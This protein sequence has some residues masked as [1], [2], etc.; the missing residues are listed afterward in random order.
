MPETGDRH[1]VIG[2]KQG[3]GTT[4]IGRGASL[5]GD[6]VA[7]GEIVIEGS[8]E[9]SLRADGAR[10]T[11]GQGAQV[12]ADVI[13]Q[14]VIVEGHVYGAIRASER[15]ELRSTAVVDGNVYSK[16]FSMEEE[17]VLRGSVDPSQSGEAAKAVETPATYAAPIPVISLAQPSAG[18]A[19]TLFGGMRPAGQMPVGLAAAARNLGDGVSPVG[20]SALSDED[21]DAVTETT[22]NNI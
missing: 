21:L 6:L 7:T 5:R 15:V 22:G 13:A 16:R 10:I 14:E 4:T 8:I 20:M 2:T 9:G 3:E 12:R 11:V 18:P 19:P 17:A 1:T